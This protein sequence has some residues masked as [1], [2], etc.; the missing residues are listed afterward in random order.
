MK[1]ILIIAEIFQGR[2]Q[3][4]TYELVSAAH[5]ILKRTAPVKVR[6]SDTQTGIKIIVPA[7]S[8]Q[9]LSKL[10]SEKT[11]LHVIGLKIPGLKVY[12][13][14]VY[15]TYLHMLLREMTPS[16]VLVAHT[17]QG[18]D[19]APG[20]SL[21]LNAASLAGVIR[22]ASDD[23][24]L[25]FVRSVLNNTKHMILR[26]KPDLPVVL[27]LTPGSFKPYNRNTCSNETVEIREVLPPAISDKR[28]H[29][30]KIKQKPGDNK[31]LKAADVIVAAGRGLKNQENLE[32]IFKFS[33]CFNNS[34]VGASRPLIDMGWIG[35]GHQVGITGAT[36][37]P[38]LYIACGI[39]G[40]SQ[41][42]AGMLKSH[43]VVCINKSPDA[44]MRRHSDLCITEDVLE[45][46]QVFIEL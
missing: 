25:T 17:A 27:T 1:P 2:V 41:H 4:V 23:Q 32:W 35:H 6:K 10:L 37:S 19:F 8:P 12:T 46:I 3:P 45:F 22:I 13:A 36:V 14:E 43:T 20:L 15:I 24:G 26:P 11:G 7:D 38:G 34:A 29:H 21:R 42:L 16:H 28:I 33:K 5:E 30:L 31:A 39:S 18:R 44:P 9:L 40:S